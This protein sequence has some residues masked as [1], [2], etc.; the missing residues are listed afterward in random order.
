[1]RILLALLFVLGCAKHPAGHPAIDDFR[2]V[3]HATLLTFN[4]LLHQQRSNAIDELGLADAI[5]KEVLPPWRAMRT[6]VDAA[7]VPADQAELYATLRRY[8]AE[9]QTAWE[10]Y[11][12]ALRAGSEPASKPHYAAYHEQDALADADA[13]KLGAAFRSL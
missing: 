13:R 2:A 10:A 1:M 3:E 6:R 4:D 8:V 5:D 12:A 9:R 7:D 11:A